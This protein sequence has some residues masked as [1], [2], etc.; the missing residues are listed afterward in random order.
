MALRACKRLVGAGQPRQRWPPGLRPCS[1]ASS[2]RSR[3]TSNHDVAWRGRRADAS[4]EPTRWGIL[5]RFGKAGSPGTKPCRR[6]TP[7]MPVALCIMRL[8][9]RS[10]CARQM[11]LCATDRPRSSSTAGA[12][13]R[14]PLRSPVP[15]RGSAPTPRTLP[16]ARCA[17]EPAPRGAPGWSDVD[18]SSPSTAVRPTRSTPPPRRTPLKRGD[19]HTPGARTWSSPHTRRTARG[20]ACVCSAARLA[21]PRAP[22]RSASG[23]HRAVLSGARRR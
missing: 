19:P 22:S 1:G 17:R 12:L 14:A 20:H 11:L 5:K 6:A 21:P 23:A 18:G 16:S 10:T 2:R 7:C 3:S 15:T 9:T 4:Q 8:T 13:A